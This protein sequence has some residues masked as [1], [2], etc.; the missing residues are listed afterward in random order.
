MSSHTCKCWASGVT[1][2]SKLTLTAALKIAWEMIEGSSGLNLESASHANCG[3]RW[4]AWYHVLQLSFHVCKMGGNNYSQ[5]GTP[6][7]VQWLK[8]P[9]C[10][11]GDVG[12]IPGQ[13]SKIL[14]TTQQLSLRASTRVQ[15]KIPH[16]PQ[17]KTPH[18]ATKIRCSQINKY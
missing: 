12:S 9:L 13:G 2:N 4:Q 14:H 18:A 15:Q 6:L 8:I 17:Q 5:P 7:V 16:A 1:S 11:S 3:D 10:N